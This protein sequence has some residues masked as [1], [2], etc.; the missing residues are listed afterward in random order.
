MK[1]EAVEGRPSASTTPPPTTRNAR[2]EQRIGLPQGQDR[3]PQRHLVCPK[4]N[5]RQEG[6][7]ARGQELGDFEFTVDRA[8]APHLVWM[9]G[10]H[11]PD[12]GIGEES[13]ETGRR[14]TGPAAR[15]REHGPS[16][17]RVA[18]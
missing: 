6:P 5:R 17:P 9:S 12:R 8:L 11:R 18:R 3:S 4:L 2:S 1:A 10:Q 13:R 16:S 15:G 7:T 14:D